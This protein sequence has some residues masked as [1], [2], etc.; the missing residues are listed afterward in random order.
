MDPNAL[1]E[2]RV[3]KRRNPL[4]ESLYE[5]IDAWD[6][7]RMGVHEFLRP[8][9]ECAIVSHARVLLAMPEATFQEIWSWLNEHAQ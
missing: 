4:Y 6:D 1:L 5:L 3:L 9:I 2:I 7:E 8:K